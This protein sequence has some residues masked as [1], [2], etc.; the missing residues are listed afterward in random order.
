MTPAEVA[1]ALAAGQITDL[2][3]GMDDAT[4]D[5]LSEEQIRSIWTQLTNALGPMESI[6][7]GIVVH[8]IPLTFE[9]GAAHLQVAYRDGRIAGLAVQEGAP[10][11]R[12]GL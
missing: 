11:G 8:D 10:T 9:R 7:D 2:R 1:R 3:D 6:G 4:R 5:G 12:F